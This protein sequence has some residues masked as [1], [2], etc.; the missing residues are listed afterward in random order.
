MAQKLA[1]KVAVVTGAGGGIGREAV[2]AMAAEGAKIVVADIGKEPDGSYS[3]DK[4]AKEIKSLGGEAVANYDNVA[5]MAGGENIIKAATKNF[6]RIDILVNCAGN[7]NA[8]PTIEMTEQD[9]DSIIAVHLKGMF[10]CTQ[11]AL[12]E[13]LKQKSG[14]IINISSTAAFPPEVRS[15]TIAYGTAKAGVLGFTLMLSMEM[16][17][18][19]ITVNALIPNA[20]TKLFPMQRQVFGGGMRGAPGDVAP[21][22]TYLTTD[23]AKDITGQFI[24]SCGGDICVFNRPNQFPGPHMFVR[25]MGKW[26]VDELSV[27]IPQMVT[28]KK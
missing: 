18:N 21:V 28:A 24:Y 10:A 11:A 16:A 13:M 2:L 25:K 23:E 19:G 27:L 9:W 7:F 20:V 14:R 3:A 22:I 17:P 12:K 1:G 15:A 4:V 6:G 5:S 8:K 26:S